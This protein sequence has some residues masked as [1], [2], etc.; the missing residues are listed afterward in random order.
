MKYQPGQHFTPSLWYNKNVFEN[1]KTVMPP[2]IS[3]I[4]IHDT[5]PYF[6]IL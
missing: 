1:E 6:I 3:Y 2:P 4:Q 5:T